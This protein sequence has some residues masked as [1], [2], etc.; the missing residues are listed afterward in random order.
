MGDPT[1]M[2]SP[3]EVFGSEGASETVSLVLRVLFGAE[4]RRRQGWLKALR[5]QADKG[6]CGVVFAVYLRS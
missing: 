2:L 1:A 3:E 5:V 6:G 4:R